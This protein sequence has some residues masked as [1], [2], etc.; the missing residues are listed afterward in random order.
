MKII[1]GTTE[2]HIAEETACAIGKFDG[3][4][5]GHRK[6]LEQLFTQ[7][8]AGLLT[9]V[10]TFDP[11]PATFF[12]GRV[13]PELTTREE[14]RL[15]FERMGVD[16]LV[17]FPLNQATAA[18]PPETFVSRVLREN[19]NA[20]FV[21]A[22]TDLSFGAGGAGDAALLK[23]MAPRLGMRFQVIEKVCVG[24][25]EVSSSVIRKLVEAGEMR[26]AQELLGMPY[27]VSGRVVHG[28]QLGR[29]LG[30]P[31]VNLLPDS[32]KLLPPNGVYFSKIRVGEKCYSGISNVGYKPTVTNE[33]LRG[34]ETYLYD[35]NRDVYGEEITVYLCEFRRPEQ[36]F[37]SVEAL[38]CQLEADIAAGRRLCTPKKSKKDIVT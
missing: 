17:E 10:F 4:H 29:T 6:L 23:A 33:R 9:C 13:I 18:M 38:R 12:A 35:F 21:A 2:F 31:T 36:K 32:C 3:I 7:K 14:K 28:R 25:Q 27:S 19:L 8:E 1:A 11:N 37:E 24:T 15:A 22:G 5:V 20:R 30:F 34:L 16:I 26:Q